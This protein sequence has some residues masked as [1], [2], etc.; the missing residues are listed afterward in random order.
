[1]RELALPGK[2]KQAF[3][4]TSRRTSGTSTRPLPGKQ[5]QAFNTT[6]RRT[7]GTSTK[8]NVISIRS[9]SA[10]NAKTRG[11]HQTD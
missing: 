10:P 4:T 7:R 5:E 6:S 2:Q 9:L 11:L 8:P 1:M 3:N